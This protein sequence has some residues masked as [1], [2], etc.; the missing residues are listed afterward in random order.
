[1]R[2]EWIAALLL[3]G[4]ST[5]CSASTISVLS[6]LSPRHARL[7]LRKPAILTVSGTGQAP[8]ERRELAAGQALEVELFTGALLLDAKRTRA[9]RL[10]LACEGG[11]LTDIRVAGMSRAYHGNVTLQPDDNTI[12]IVLS[13]P[14][15]ELVGSIVESERL[16]AASPESLRALAVVARSFLQA[17]SRHPGVEFC[18]TTHCQ[19]FQG[20]VAGREVRE[21]VSATSGMILLYKARPFRP[22]YSR[23]CGG[24]T[25]T[26]QE[27]WG[28]PSPDY[29]F[30]SMECPCSREEDTGLDHPRGAAGDL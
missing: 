23:S 10:T 9:S 12:Q 30:A 26:Y 11:C 16:P 8:P 29:P 28:R 4:L 22:Y 27:V 6:L 3:V 20:L 1:M 13:I 21:A 15:E 5:A 25:A 19:V 14:E 7:V 18:D 24:K 2:S 17:G